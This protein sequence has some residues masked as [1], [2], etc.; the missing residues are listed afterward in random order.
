MNE[1]MN[2]SMNE[3]R[4]ITRVEGSLISNYNILPDHKYSH[5]RFYW[6]SKVFFSVR[7]L[8]GWETIRAGR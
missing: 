3:E 6:S 4:I 7:L 5:V 1:S 8:L 2:E